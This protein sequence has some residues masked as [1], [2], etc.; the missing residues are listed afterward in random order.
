MYTQGED[1]G[2]VPMN[3]EDSA[4]A[5]AAYD[6]RQDIANASMALRVEQYELNLQHIRRICETKGDLQAVVRVIEEGMPP[7]IRQSTSWS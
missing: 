2:Y 5:L 7:T 4:A 1:G 6:A 3:D